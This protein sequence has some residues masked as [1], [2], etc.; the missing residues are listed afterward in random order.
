MPLS[1]AEAE[2]GSVQKSVYQLD[3]LL[4]GL[5]KASVSKKIAGRGASP[6]P[7][8]TLDGREQQRL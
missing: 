4:F 7:W 6:T 1:Q 5:I 8:R 2:A 3:V